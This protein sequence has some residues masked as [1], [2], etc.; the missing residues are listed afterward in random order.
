LAERAD[1]PTIKGVVMASDCWMKTRR[2][3]DIERSPWNNGLE[4]RR[5][6]RAQ[7]PTNCSLVE[8]YRVNQSLESADGF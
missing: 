5:N 7:R 4:S 2:V 6:I 8:I 3:D 1:E